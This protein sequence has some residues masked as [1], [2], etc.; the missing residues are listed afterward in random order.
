ME[1]K[2]EKFNQSEDIMMPESFMPDTSAENKPDEITNKIIHMT[3]PM[4]FIKI[5]LF[6]IPSTATM[7]Y[8]RDRERVKLGSDKVKF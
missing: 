3:S 4:Y 2:M 6:L 5:I 7:F 1:Y 8:I